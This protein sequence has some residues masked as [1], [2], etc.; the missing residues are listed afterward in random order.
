VALGKQ[1]IERPKRSTHLDRMSR[2]FHDSAAAPG[3][4]QIS[5]NGSQGSALPR[6]GDMLVWTRKSSTSLPIDRLVRAEIKQLHRNASGSAASR[7]T[8]T[9]SVGSKR[10]SVKSDPCVYSEPFPSTPAAAGNQDGGAV[11]SSMGYLGAGRRGR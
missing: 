4:V 3:S 9:S 6:Q 5:A 2:P 10:I 8:L 7:N 11:N 1:L